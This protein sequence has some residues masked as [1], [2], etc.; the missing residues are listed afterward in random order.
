MDQAR[1]LIVVSDETVL[2]EVLRL[3]AAVGCVV[4]RGADLPEARGLWGRRHWW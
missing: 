3:A 2:D 1:A 4:Q